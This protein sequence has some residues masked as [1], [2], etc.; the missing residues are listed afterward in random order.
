IFVLG[1]LLY[2]AAAIWSFTKRTWLFAVVALLVAGLGLSTYLFLYLRAGLHPFINEADA[3]TLH[4]LWAVIGREQYPPRS[5]FDNPMFQSGLGNPH[6]FFQPFS[7]DDPTNTYFTLRIIGLQFLNWLQYFDW[8]WASSLMRHMTLLAPAR[9]PFTILFT[10]LGI[11]G[12]QEH[13]KWDRSSFWLIATLFA[14]TSLGLVIYLNF[15]PGFSIGLDSFPDRD[16][17]EVRE[18]DYFFTISFLTWGL[19]AGAGIAVLFR[20]LRDRLGPQ[21]TMAAS[22]ILLLALLPAILNFNAAN[23]KFGPAAM[24]AHDFAYDMLIG[25]PPYGILFTNGDNDTF[26][27]WYIQ[28]VEEVRQDVMIVNLSLANTDWYI[29]QLRDLPAR[30][31]R[32]DANAI[33]LFGRDAGPP[34]SCNDRQLAALNAMA[35]KAE[36]H[37]PDLS[38]GRPMC[39]HTLTDDQIDQMQ[40][41][42]LQTNLPLDVGNIHHVYRANTPM[43]VKDIL[44]LRLIEE[45]LG[46]RPIVF[47]LTAG[48]GNRQGLDAYVVE[49]GLGF[50]LLPDT[51]RLGGNIA[52]VRSFQS[53]IDLQRTR[54]LLDSV[55]KYGK[56]MQTDSLR[57][58]PTDDQ[59]AYNLAVVYYALAEGY[60]Q[61]NNLAAALPE[62]KKTAH[63]TTETSLNDYIRQIEAAAAAAAA[64]PPAAPP[65]A[66]APAAHPATRPA[67]HPP[68]RGTAK[69]P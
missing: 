33:R 32:P 28:E 16:I 53:A 45:N 42:L 35:D 2:I 15:K 55:Y 59:I 8:Q 1:A 27:L 66:P 44:I 22:P 23:R 6:R 29:R 13:R 51:V 65:A 30:P 24:L 41:M 18:R 56:L 67:A 3:S 47:A 52:P 49:E 43:Y 31:Y 9:L 48:T 34:P 17:H 57:L 10:A 62:L 61:Q 36:R 37:R 64:A 25:V 11:L 5:P 40:P 38:R 50:R 39:L 69:R 14:T 68:A 46:K 7:N 20:K 19:W 4:N 26:P 54:V 21:S 12:A 58:E 63:L 60:I